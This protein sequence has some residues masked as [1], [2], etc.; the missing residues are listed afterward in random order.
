[1]ARGERVHFF[2][3]LLE[4]LRWF[5]C[6]YVLSLLKYGNETKCMKR[7]LCSHGRKNLVSDE[8]RNHDFQKA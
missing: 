3:C 6:G 2:T 4:S 7:K 5:I 8:N 1:M